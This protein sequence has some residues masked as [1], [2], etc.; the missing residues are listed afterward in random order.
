MRE[1]LDW[2]RHSVTNLVLELCNFLVASHDGLLNDRFLALQLHYL[3][4][5]MIVLPCLLND[6]RLELFKVS[7]DVRV[8][9]LHVLIVLGGEVVL[10]EADFLSKH[11]DLLLVLSQARLAK[12]DPVFDALDM[13]T[14]VILG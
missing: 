10:H 13:T 2:C 4:L 6:A 3:F 1:S 8:D 12:S 7:H 14:N 5:H 11:L 9:D